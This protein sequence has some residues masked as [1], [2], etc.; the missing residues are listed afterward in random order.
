MSVKNKRRKKE[1]Q[2][3][4]RPVFLYDKKIEYFVLFICSPNSLLES[5]E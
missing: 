2:A 4:L 5:L 3:I 1:M